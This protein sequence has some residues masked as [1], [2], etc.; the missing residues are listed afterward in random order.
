MYCPSCGNAVAEG[1][2]YCNRCG[3]SLAAGDR[4][5][6][7][8]GLNGPA[9]AISLATALVTLGGLA[10]IFVISLQLIARRVDLSPGAGV[11]MLV[12]LAVIAL[13]DLM[14]IRQLSRVIDLHR[15]APAPRR[16]REAAA[17]RPALEEKQPARLDAMREPPLS[18]IDQTT[19][20]LEHSPRERDTR[21]QS[22]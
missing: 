5:A 15:G 6:S 19:R 1:L 3:E 7:V 2:K 11:I 18:V 10:M 20:T 16:R 21:P 4:A 8:A 12:F 22:D 14:L 17:E 13:V 9:W